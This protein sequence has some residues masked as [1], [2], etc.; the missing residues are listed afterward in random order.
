MRSI[1]GEEGIEEKREKK[2]AVRFARR[3]FFV[4]RSVSFGGVF[5]VALFCRKKEKGKKRGKR[6]E[7]H[8]C[9]SASCPARR[10]SLCLLKKAAA[11]TCDRLNGVM[12][13]QTSGYFRERKGI[14]PSLRHTQRFCKPSLFQKG[15][16]SRLL[17]IREAARPVSF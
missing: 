11:K 15:C 12:L 3:S 13:T 14:F 6:N 5:F 8:C 1:A 9:S 10:F 7:E 4:Q 17:P 2:S 16:Q